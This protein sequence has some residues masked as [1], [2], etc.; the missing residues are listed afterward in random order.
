MLCPLGLFKS[1]NYC[2]VTRILATQEPPSL[3][4]NI[5]PPNWPNTPLTK[6][7]H[8]SFPSFNFRS[9]ACKPPPIYTHNSN[10]LPL[11]RTANHNF[12]S[13]HPIF[14]GGRCP[15]HR[16]LS[17]PSRRTTTTKSSS[18]SSLHRLLTIPSSRIHILCGAP[19]LLQWLTHVCN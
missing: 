9:S 18:P 17:F 13:G 15:I 12:P 1:Y 5:Q 14:S 7:P 4:V 8:E 11:P 16:W 6:Q 19:F 3:P 2:T 10:P